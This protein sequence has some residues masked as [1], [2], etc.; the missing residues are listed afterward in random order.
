LR[1]VWR[2]GDSV[3]GGC[4]AHGNRAGVLC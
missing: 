1:I 4:G 2:G 3:E